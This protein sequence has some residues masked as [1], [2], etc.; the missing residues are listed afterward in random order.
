MRRDFKRAELMVI[1][2]SFD[3]ERVQ[4]YNIINNVELVHI[5][6]DIENQISSKMS[7]CTQN[8]PSLPHKAKFLENSDGFYNS[9]IS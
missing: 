9:S 8:F 3:N 5:T 1:W 2:S 6:K 7:R 4:I